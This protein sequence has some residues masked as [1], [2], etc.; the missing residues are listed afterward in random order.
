MAEKASSG[1]DL[2]WFFIEWI[3]SSGA[4]EF[5]LEYTIFRTTKGFR[6]QG[7][8]SQDLDTFRM[9]VDSEDRDGGQP[10]RE[11]RGGDGNVV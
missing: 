9:P 6:V 11:A 3:E 7:K 4:P 8:V 2:K 5:K 1:Q 10:G